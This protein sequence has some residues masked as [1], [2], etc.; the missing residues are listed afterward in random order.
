[1]KPLAS[2]LLV[3]ALA[4][5]NNRPELPPR[6]LSKSLS[7][8]AMQL[9][10]ATEPAPDANLA[11]PLSIDS[12]ALRNQQPLAHE[13]QEEPPPVDRATAAEPPGLDVEVTKRLEQLR[14][15]HQ[16]K[17]SELERLIEEKRAAAARQPAAIAQPP[18]TTPIAG[19]P[20]A[21]EA[22]LEQLADATAKSPPLPAPGPSRAP[23]LIEPP[24]LEYPKRARRSNRQAV[25]VVLVQVDTSGRVVDAVLE[26]GQAPSADFAA[27][28]L[29]AARQA[30]YDPALELGRPTM[31]WTRLTLA[32]RLR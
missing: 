27:A 26:E 11:I 17:V 9:A 14:L 12:P 32:Y 20:P 19:P 24:A 2:T 8:P 6:Q 30:V 18:E 28:A 1:M 7:A 10:E 22:P 13:A 21:P 5:C 15:S 29:E 4:A 31:A 25:V 23:R 3:L 16:Q